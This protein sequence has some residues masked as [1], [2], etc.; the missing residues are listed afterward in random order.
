MT[1]ELRFRRADAS[2]Y[3]REHWGVSF[4]PTTLAKLATIGGGPVFEKFGRWPV[5]KQ[6]DLDAWIESRRS[7]PKLSTS[8]DRT[9]PSVELAGIAPDSSRGGSMP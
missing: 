4:A 8:D 3:M 5:Y 7:G 2:Q 6:S 9:R 1:T